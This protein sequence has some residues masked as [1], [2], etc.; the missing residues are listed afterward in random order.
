MISLAWPI[1]VLLI[2]FDLTNQAGTGTGGQQVWNP[3]SSH[4]PCLKESGLGKLEYDIVSGSNV[5]KLTDLSTVKK[6]EKGKYAQYKPQHL[7]SISKH[8]LENGNK[9]TK[10]SY[11]CKF[12]NLSE[13][14]I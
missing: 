4:M 13:S 11:S 7:S 8:S 6:K 1:S 10:I 9:R 12:P 3:T 2:Q 14:A 5:S